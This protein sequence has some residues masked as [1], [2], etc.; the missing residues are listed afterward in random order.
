MLNICYE[1]F[2]RRTQ[3][4]LA[5][6]PGKISISPHLEILDWGFKC[7]RENL[8]ECKCMCDVCSRTCACT[9]SRVHSP[10]WLDGLI[11]FGSICIWMQFPLY[12]SNERSPKTVS[13]IVFEAALHWCQQREAPAWPRGHL[14][15]ALRG[16]TSEPPVVPSAT[17][18]AQA[19][20]LKVGKDD[21]F[22]ARK[23]SP[24]GQ[25]FHLCGLWIFQKYLAPR[26]CPSERTVM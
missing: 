3:E 2:I 23:Y 8:C 7:S 15:G 22:E 9:H 6:L 12:G 4:Q 1:I 17:T 21:L 20:A 14:A 18:R 13:I 25:I 19:C 24:G 16:A 26:P 11:G 10:A 5:K